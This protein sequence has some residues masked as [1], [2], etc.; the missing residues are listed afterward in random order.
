MF[1]NCLDE[2]GIDDNDR[3]IIAFVS[4]INAI[5]RSGERVELL[6]GNELCR[7]KTL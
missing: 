5:A 1:F 3:R 6:I 4:R 7:M 2:T